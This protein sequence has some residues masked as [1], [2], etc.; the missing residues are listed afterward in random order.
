MTF[1]S[2]DSHRVHEACNTG[3][4]NFFLH[5]LN[6]AAEE[7]TERSY[8]VW[9]KFHC[10]AIS[11]KELMTR[12]TNYLT[13]TKISSKKC[14]AYTASI[15]WQYGKYNTYR[16]IDSDVLTL[17]NIKT[18]QNKKTFQKTSY[19]CNGFSS[20]RWNVKYKCIRDVIQKYTKGWKDFVPLC[21]LLVCFHQKTII[22]ES[23]SLKKMSTCVNF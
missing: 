17:N 8:K 16:S 7:D 19:A 1:K 3:I 11:E 9:L 22:Y 21:S 23:I 15:N 6:S 13:H 5:N 4:M 10:I 12:R 20:F 14:L 18:K 2:I